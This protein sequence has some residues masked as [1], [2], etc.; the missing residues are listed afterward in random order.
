MSLNNTSQQDEATL[1]N[2]TLPPAAVVAPPAVEQPV[3]LEGMHPEEPPAAAAAPQADSLSSPSPA[4]ELIQPPPPPPPP[5]HEPY[6]SGPPGPEPKVP[7]ASPATRTGPG[8]PPQ[9]AVLTACLLAHAFHSLSA[10]LAHTVCLTE[11][12]VCLWLPDKCVTDWSTCTTVGWETRRTG[13]HLSLWPGWRHP[14]PAL[15]VASLLPLHGS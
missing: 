8:P 11:P 13:I 3:Q 1:S 6:P 7:A 12:T 14:Q 9:P 4:P 10:W 5:P 2:P 15:T